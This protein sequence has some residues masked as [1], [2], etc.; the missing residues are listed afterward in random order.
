MTSATAADAAQSPA[1]LRIWREPWASHVLVGITSVDHDR[2]IALASGRVEARQLAASAAID[3]ELDIA[4]QAIARVGRRGRRGVLDRWN[5][6]SV[7]RAY[8]G[9]HAAKVYL[10]DVLPL[11]SVDALVPGVAARLGTC[12]PASDVRRLDLDGLIRQPEH[13]RRAGLKVAMSIAYEASDQLHAQ[14]RGFRNVL[15][16][17]AALITLLMGVLVTIVSHHPDAMPLCFTPSVTSQQASAQGLN[18]RTVCPS[19]DEPL[20]GAASIADRLRPTGADVVIVAG[21]GLLGGALGAVFAIRK[22]R[23]TSTP[24]DIP[25]AV[26]LL[27]VP[28]GSL[29][30]VAGLLLLGGGF[31]PGLSELDSQ[32]QV[33]AY[34][35]LFGYAQQLATRFIDD[36]AQSILDHVP[37]KDPQGKQPTA[38]LPRVPPPPPP[39]APPGPLA[40][41]AELPGKILGHQTP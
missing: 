19:G 20:D 3:K 16:S 17:A 8:Q 13:R 28:T 14:I 12:L 40:R 30:A 15:F 35:L 32:R 11:E 36:R 33:C 39:P 10:V 18:S 26:A 9:L 29:T 24:Y 1:G 6:V 2:L 27:K 22:M 38:P 25:I 31:V 23:G 37:S 21:L 4:R 5:G 41:L 7:E 34:A